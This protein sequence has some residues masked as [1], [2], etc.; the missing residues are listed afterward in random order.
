MT[1]PVDVQTDTIEHPGFEWLNRAA[2]GDLADALEASSDADA[3]EEDNRVLGL[4]FVDAGH[5]ISEETLNVCRAC[6]V[7]RECII[8][9]YVGGPDASP[10]TGGYIGG[11]SLGQRKT[12][13]VEQAL[14]RAENDPPKPIRRKASSSK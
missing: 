5:V 3:A 8:H 14:T 4:F 1:T 6:P 10:I 7:R 11:F 13:T 12:M 2:C 9:A